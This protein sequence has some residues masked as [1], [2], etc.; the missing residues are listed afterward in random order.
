MAAAQAA[1]AR[2]LAT[3]NQRKIEHDGARTLDELERT[4]TELDRAT[5]IHTLAT[6]DL[7]AAQDQLQHAIADVHSAEATVSAQVLKITDARA[8]AIAR[9]I[10]SAI[11]HL[12]DLARHLRDWTTDEF[13]TPINSA[14]RGYS[15]TV[16]RALD[17]T[18]PPVMDLYRPLNE[19]RRE[20]VLGRS[21]AVRRAEL[22]AGDGEEASQAA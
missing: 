20:T 10:V 18:A 12:D 17:L 2:A 19:I 16:Q 11:A 6:R 4:K 22:M 14:L 3:Q 5:D 13:N 15:A 7:Q 8:E 9:E 1:V 21:L